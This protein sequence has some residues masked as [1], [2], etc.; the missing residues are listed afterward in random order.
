MRTMK[1]SIAFLASWI[2]LVHVPL[3]TSVAQDGSNPPVQSKCSQVVDRAFQFSRR[4][5]AEFHGIELRI[6]LRFLPSFGE[7]ESQF[8]FQKGSQGIRIIEYRL[9]ERARPISEQCMEILGE[10]PQASV[11]DILRAI[12][13]QRVERMLSPTSAQLVQELSRLAVPTNL[14]SDLT[15]DGTKYELW[16]QTAS[17]EIHAQFSDGAYGD[18]TNSTPIILWMKA[19]KAEIE[20]K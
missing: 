19:V 14:S 13:V 6:V 12:V 20:R 5:P 16:V 4:I 11:E 15:L 3:A 17:N 18:A 9:H 10:N 8:V 7:E 2:I 1:R